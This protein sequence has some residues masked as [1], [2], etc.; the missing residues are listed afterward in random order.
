MS[1]SVVLAPVVDVEIQ[2]S[3]AEIEGGLVPF[4]ISRIKKMLKRRSLSVMG[5]S[6]WEDP[7]RYSIIMTLHC[8]RIGLWIPDVERR[9]V[10][11]ASLLH[12][13]RSIQ[14]MGLAERGIFHVLDQP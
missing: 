8:W 11:D 14:G 7:C 12:F 5:H 1:T 6:T 4:I 9:R 10:E 3:R 2:I 13:K